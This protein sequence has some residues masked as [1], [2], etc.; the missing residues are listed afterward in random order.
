LTINVPQT[1]NDQTFPD[2]EVRGY[3][4]LYIE[5]GI[6][7]LNGYDTLR[8]AR[9]RHTSSD[10]GRAYRQQQILAALADQIT[11][12]IKITQIKKIEE[13]YQK[14]NEMVFTNIKPN[15]AI[16]MAQ[17]QE[18]LEHFFSYVLTYECMNTYSMMQP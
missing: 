2:R 16:Y 7:T 17:Y 10:F 14:V 4:P 15:N 3:D 8:Y 13:L 18:K 1:I 12:N 6:Q 11:Q 9:S 5:S